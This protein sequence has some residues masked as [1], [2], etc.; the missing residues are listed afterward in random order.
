MSTVVISTIKLCNSLLHPVNGA[1]LAFM[2]NAGNIFQTETGC[3]ACGNRALA[4]HGSEDAISLT[5]AMQRSLSPQSDRYDSSD[6][7]NGSA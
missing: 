6:A 1:H 3:F 2:F 7:Y 5:G 4:E